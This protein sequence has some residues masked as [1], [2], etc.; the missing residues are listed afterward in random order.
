MAREQ[1]SNT[2]VE[3][4]QRQ[5]ALAPQQITEER[6]LYPSAINGSRW[7]RVYPYQ[8]LVVERQDDGTYTPLRSDIQGTSW[9]FTLP[10]P[11]D[12][13][14]I[15]TPFAINTS[16]TLG[17]YI[18]EHNGIPLR[19]IS[20]SGTTG[21]FP[22][23]DRAAPLPDFSGLL[24]S[25]QAIFAGTIAA[26]SATANSFD[27]LVNGRTFTTNAVPQ[28]AFE[29][30][31]DSASLTGYYQ[32]RL[33]ELFFEAYA[34]LKRTN[35]DL[36]RRCRLAFA[37]WKQEQVYLVT[38]VN[39][40]VPRSAQ[41][42][43][44]YRYNL[45]FK[46]SKRV[47]LA[48]GKADIV[49]QYIPVQRDP[50]KLAQLLNKV[51]QI[52]SV[53]Q[54]AR[55][56]VTAVGGDVEHSLFEPMR[57]LTLM[58]KD[59]LAVP[60]SVADL[61]DALIQDTKAA[62]VD[63]RSTTDDVL[64]FPTNFRNRF[65]QTSKSASEIDV[66][67]GALAAE[68]TDDTAAPS[69]RI[70]SRDAHPANSPFLNPKDNYD[71]FSNIRVGDLHLPAST[72]SRIAA[73]RTRVRQ[74]TRLDYEKRRDNV[75]KAAADFSNAL[76][77]GSS[78]YNEVYGITPPTNPRV[79]NPTDDDY[80]AIY[81]MND[82]IVELNR[83]VVTNDNDPNPKL[84]SIAVV[85][86]LAAQSGIAF[87][88]PTSKFAVP[89]PYGSTLEMLSA[90][91]LGDPGRWYEI[92]ALN[93]LQTPYVDEEGFRLP[94]LVNGAGNTIIVSDKTHLFV[95]QPVW[96]ESV[97]VVRSKRRIT[98]IRQLAASQVLVTVDGDA[99]LDQFT[100]MAQ[101]FVQAFLPNTINSQM[102]VYIPSEQEPKDEDF[103]TK[104]IPGVNDYDQLISVG[105]IDL[106][107]TPKNDL[108]ITPNGDVRWA[109]GLTNIIQKIR[110]ALTVKQGTL[111]E[112]PDYGLPIAVGDS[113]ADTDATN[114]LRA[115]QDLFQGDP[116]F[117]GV[118]GA[119]V[120]INGP[121]TQ[122]G[123]AVEIAG[124]SQV[125]PVSAEVSS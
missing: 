4:A 67:I 10:I 104:A 23:R 15:S 110:I 1:A 121:V 84:D 34:E 6:W 2:S 86:G 77:I 114:L 79:T 13:M 41:S 68:Q 47:K 118:K 105:G 97:G 66:Q 62:I 60:L 50:G 109:V 24:G 9:T 8:I 32:F 49:K 40:E 3:E 33:L 75:A 82:F 56:T 38:P 116:T 11:P 37:I 78:T 36:G 28:T 53:L 12:A 21:V 73:E 111:L 5:N 22:G 94:L 55:K 48:P 65:A 120:N 117:L 25:T 72:V 92:A 29:S 20:L 101:S 74:L 17:G 39:F 108:I 107:L 63:L 103:K 76:G 93:G 58:A 7:N 123:L 26:A 89:F 115:A 44:E 71:F 42:P 102:V 61:G 14:S 59:A 69:S 70:L 52:R 46:A 18:E 31:S 35:T 95:N 106:L 83:L 113:I 90:R 45:S 16:V 122:L 27:T 80:E 112:H 125:I 100:T 51:Q 96:I 30:L 91:Y 98:K 85:A 57:E 64:N 87:K 88:T 99:N 19:M 124:L 81:A 119:R 43:L 54:N